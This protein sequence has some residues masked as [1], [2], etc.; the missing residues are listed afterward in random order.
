MYGDL[1]RP[2]LRPL[3]LRRALEPEGWRVE[4]LP[5]TGST[6]AVVAA[7]AAAGEPAG[8][9][10][11]AESQTS[12][13]GRLDR[14]WTSPPRAG[15][16]FSVLLRPSLPLARWGWLPL[17]GGLAVADALRDRCRVDAV[18]KWPN[19]VLVGGEK[20]CGLLAE[21]VGGAL[22][23]GIG[24]N[25]T[26]TREELPPDRPATSLLLAGAATTDRDTLLRAVLRSLDRTLAAADAD[27]Y[28]ARCSSI[29]QRVRV[30]LPTGAVEGTVTSVDDD[31]RIVVDGTPYGAGDVV[32][33]RPGSGGAGSG[34]AGSGP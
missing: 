12:G 28:R 7:R 31:G 13:R 1:D 22:V 4:V 24:L 23:L 30:E 14:V 29:G 34:G 3:A 8:L 25:V 6:N 19:D 26:T 11:V 20:V 5:E 9:V 16:T 18:V 15:L 27:A 32:H 10:V 33:L 2:P 17:W 21:A